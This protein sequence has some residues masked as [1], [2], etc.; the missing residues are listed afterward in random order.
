MME[1]LTSWVSRAF[2]LMAF[3][4]MGVAIWEKLINLMDLTFLRGYAPSRLLEFAAISMLFV[5]ALQLRAVKL[6]KAD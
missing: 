1:K 6:V 5:I 2:F 4:L 3:L